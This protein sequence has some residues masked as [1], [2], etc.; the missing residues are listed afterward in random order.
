MVYSCASDA[1]LQDEPTV[2]PNLAIAQSDTQPEIS[3]E[4]KAALIKPN[5]FAGIAVGTPLS[6]LAD[7]LTKDTISNG[8]GSFTIYWIDG[9]NADE[10]LAYIDILPTDNPALVHGFTVISPEVVTPEGIYVGSTI[11]QLRKAY[12]SMS[13]HGSEI[14]SR[15]TVSG[16]NYYFRI[17]AL[18]N[19]YDLPQGFLKDDMVV[20]EIYIR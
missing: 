4:Q 19:Q 20:E 3:G 16:G 11:A 12:P 13:A 8:E 14:E 9:T 18:S 2:S 5:S 1:P 7:R 17:D 6:E 15:V 10:S